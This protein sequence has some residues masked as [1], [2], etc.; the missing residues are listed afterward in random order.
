MIGG[1]IGGLV[2]DGV[3]VD[4]GVEDGAVVGDAVMSADELN[5]GILGF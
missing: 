4:T 3:D 1:P 5:G 2:T